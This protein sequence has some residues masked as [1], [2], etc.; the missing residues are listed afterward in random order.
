MSADLAPF[1]DRLLG[2][3]RDRVGTAPLTDSMELD[4]AAEAHRAVWR[5]TRRQHHRRE[6]QS[7]HP[8][9]V[10]HAGAAVLACAS[11]R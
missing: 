5:R 8:P 4:S 9:I 6:S 2:A 11:S 7:S 3:V 1:V 10:S